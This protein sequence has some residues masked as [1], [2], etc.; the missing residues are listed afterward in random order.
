MIPLVTY[1]PQAPEAWKLD[2]C[3]KPIRHIYFKVLPAEQTI[4]VSLPLQ[5]DQAMLQQAFNSKSRWMLN[6]I[7]KAQTFSQ[8]PGPVFKPGASRQTAFRQGDTC[9]F[10]GNPYTLVFVRKKGAPNVF[11]TPDQKI[12]LQT[13]PQSSPAAQET[14]LIRFLREAL[15]ADIHTLAKIWEP[16]I[17]VCANEYRIRKM[18]TRWGSCNIRARR[19]WINQ[20]LIHLNPQFLSYVLVHELIH[21]IERQHNRRFYNLMARFVPDWK[22]LKKK[23]G[24]IAL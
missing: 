24:L 2:L 9:H 21:L 12:V 11:L 4:R 17:G 3:P 1:L 7:K 16:E 19:I 20:A 22:D 23:L 5:T 13:S 10:R 14:A 8:Q 15:M 18:R 6:Q